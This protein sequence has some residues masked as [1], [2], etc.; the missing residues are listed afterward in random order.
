[1]PKRTLYHPVSI[2]VLRG[3]LEYCGITPGRLR[4][5]GVNNAER[6]A[7]YRCDI[8]AVPKGLWS[9]SLPAKRRAI[10][11]CFAS[12]VAVM[13]YGEEYDDKKGLITA[14][15]TLCTRAVSDA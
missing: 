1:M 12:D 3:A 6:S 10:Q 4:Q 5:I 11:S 9:E 2:H 13:S 8:I 15:I 7:I 14:W